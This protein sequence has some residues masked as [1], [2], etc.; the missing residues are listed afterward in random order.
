MYVVMQGTV[1]TY[2]SSKAPTEFLNKYTETFCFGEKALQS[3]DHRRDHYAVATEP[4]YL[5]SLD[6]FD[7]LDK[8]F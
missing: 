5:L 6:R 8:T 4:T 7:F 3:E 1:Q 2:Q